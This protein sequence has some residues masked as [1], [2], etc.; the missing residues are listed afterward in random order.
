MLPLQVPKQNI[1]KYQKQPLT[2]VLR[3]ICLEK[4]RKFHRKMPMLEPLFT[5]QNRDI[6]TGLFLC[7]VKDLRWSF[8][9]KLLATESS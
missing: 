4:F 6:D 3:K 9:R 1:S 7:L 5:N 8:L 2:D